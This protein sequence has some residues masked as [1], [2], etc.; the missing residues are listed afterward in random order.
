MCNKLHNRQ[1]LLS[2]VNVFLFKLIDHHELQTSHMTFFPHEY[3]RLL[4]NQNEPKL[5]KSQLQ[6]YET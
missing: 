6:Q 5:Y 3:L 4:A 1:F 2:F